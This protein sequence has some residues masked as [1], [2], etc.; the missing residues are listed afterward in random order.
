MLEMVLMNILLRLWLDLYTIFK[1]RPEL[2][3]ANIPE[4]KKSELVLLVSPI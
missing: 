3:E 2:V 4:D 1:W